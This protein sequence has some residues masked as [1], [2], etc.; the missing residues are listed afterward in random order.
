MPSP[1]HKTDYATEALSLLTSRYQK[2]RPFS[3]S[4]LRPMMWFEST[5]GVTAPG[6]VLATWTDM[7]QVN[8]ATPA[9]SAPT[10]APSDAAFGG[11]PSVDFVGDQSASTLAIAPATDPTVMTIIVFG[12]GSD[13]SSPGVYTF[14][15]TLANNLWSVTPQGAATL[16]AG[17]RITAIVVFARLL[18]GTETAD[19]TASVHSKFG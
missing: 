3:P 6:N 13:G 10:L 19:L 15:A 14:V 7:L 9:S 12:A 2:A 18:T 11:A 8:T 1:T 16:T 17:V 4:Q 5:G